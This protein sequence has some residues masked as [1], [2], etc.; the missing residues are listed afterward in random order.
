MRTKY[1]RSHNFQTENAHKHLEMWSNQIDRIKAT[2]Q[3]W[4]V[5]CESIIKYS[6]KMDKIK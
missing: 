4:I 5:M 6:N 3:Q 2:E 1:Y